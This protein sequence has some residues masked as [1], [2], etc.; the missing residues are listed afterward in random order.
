MTGVTSGLY[1]SSVTNVFSDSMVGIKYLLV[2]EAN[3]IPHGYV[4]T[5]IEING[6]FVYENPYAFPISFMLPNENADYNTNFTQKDTFVENVYTALKNNEFEGEFYTQ[7]G[8]INLESIETLSKQLNDS[9]AEIDMRRG[10]VNANI[11]A[12]NNGLLFF[13]IPYSEYLHVT[14]NSQKVQIE[15]VFN[16]QLAVPVTKGNNTIKITYNTP[17]KI[18]GIVVSLLSACMLLAWYIKSKKQNKI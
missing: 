7:E 16:S 6:Y 4:K 15:E 10:E 8:K 3:P 13:S 14:V 18:Q 2:N 17:M 5:N 1:D 11:N 9:A 12:E